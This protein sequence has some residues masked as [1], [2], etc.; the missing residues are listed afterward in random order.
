MVLS[1]EEARARGW[2]RGWPN[3]DSPLRTAVGGGIRIPMHADL[4]DLPDLLLG[5]TGAQY[6]LDPTQCGGFNC[7]AKA[8][9]SSSPSMHSFGIAVDLNWTE[10]PMGP[11]QHTIP[12]AV[13]V[14]WEK[15]GWVWGGR[16]DYPDW[17]HFQYEGLK[18]DVDKHIA[19]AKL[20]LNPEEDDVPLP[21][22]EPI[23]WLP[24][25][26]GRVPTV[27]AKVGSDGLTRWRGRGC[28]IEGGAWKN[29]LHVKTVAS[30]PLAEPINKI[31]A[32]ESDKKVIGVAGDGGTFVVRVL[33]LP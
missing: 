21:V 17:M 24:S 22:M 33:P 14:G 11:P 26:N 8:T 18:S 27:E 4:K 7:R 6:R 31:R 25:V 1:V 9:N 16:W 30:V 5:W 20:L 12:E 10:N 2:G 28:R 32:Y 13:A 29:G 19:V 23:E 3:C 15:C